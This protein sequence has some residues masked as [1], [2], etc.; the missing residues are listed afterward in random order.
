VNGF[1]LI[2]LMIVVAIIGILA[3]IALPAYQD[4]TARARVSEGLMLASDPKKL[5]AESAMTQS[6]LANV[7]ATFNAQAGGTGANS[8]YVSRIQI[9]AITG[10]ITITFNDANVGSIPAAATMRV[11]PYVLPDNVAAVTLQTALSGGLSGPIDWACTSDSNAAAAQKGMPSA[12]VGT[13]P[14]KIAPSECR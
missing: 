12:A 8:K 4:L 9:D 14:R 6:E 2:E 7:A 3:S 11:S 13:L 1:T 5:V 10:V